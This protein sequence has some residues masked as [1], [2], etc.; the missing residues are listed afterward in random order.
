MKKV[1]GSLLHLSLSQLRG[2]WPENVE[3]PLMYRRE[4]DRQTDRD[5]EVV[6]V[7]ASSLCQLRGPWPETCYIYLLFM[8]QKK[9]KKKTRRQ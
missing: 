3:D 1:V 6:G 4:R 5:R 2:P 8:L 7:P 9:R